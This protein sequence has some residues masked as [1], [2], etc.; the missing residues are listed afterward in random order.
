MHRLGSEQWTKAKQKALEKIRDVA[1]EL[2]DIHAQRAIKNGHAFLVE[3]EDYQQFAQTFPFE[4][5]PDQQTA[6]DAI[7]KLQALS[8]VQM[9]GA[10]RD[11]L[12]QGR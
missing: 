10:L 3:N 5:T 7:Q 4:E 1:A 12:L 11:I 9:E 2:L 6:I 8:E